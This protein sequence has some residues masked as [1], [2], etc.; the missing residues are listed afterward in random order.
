[1]VTAAKGVVMAADKLGKTKTILQ[2]VSII[3]FFLAGE[4]GEDGTI[5]ELFKNSAT[6][7][8]IHQIILVTALVLFALA[9]IMTVISGVH[10]VLVYGKKLETK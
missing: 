6:V 1:M 5:K 2:D 4:F 9:V 3:F 8:G 7:D 10:Y